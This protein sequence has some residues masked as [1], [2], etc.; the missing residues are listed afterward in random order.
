MIV[1]DVWRAGPRHITDDVHLC[2]L[3]CQDNT[4][5]IW[6]GSGVSFSTLEDRNKEPA[7]G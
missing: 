7:A 4:W 1:E 3:K 6:E 2:H 5:D